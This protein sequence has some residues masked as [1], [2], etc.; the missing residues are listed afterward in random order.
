MGCTYQTTTFLFISFTLIIQ[1]FCIYPFKYN[2][3]TIIFFPLLQW[4]NVHFDNVNR[5]SIEQ[6]MKMQVVVEECLPQWEETGFQWIGRTKDLGKMEWKTGILGSLI[7]ESVESSF[8]PEMIR[9][10][11]SSLMIHT[12][13]RSGREM[14]LASSKRLGRVGRKKMGLLEMQEVRVDFRCARLLPGECRTWTSSC[15]STRRLEL[16]CGERQ[17]PRSFPFVGLVLGHFDGEWLRGSGTAC[18]CQI[19]WKGS[20]QSLFFVL[21]T[22]DRYS[23]WIR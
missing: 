9:W 18:A 10:A 3:M 12:S 17:R 11:S 19:W 20:F 2:D 15:L 23:S 1:E 7:E 16:L 4:K 22:F 6:R 14:M 13:S 5:D 21:L 8:D